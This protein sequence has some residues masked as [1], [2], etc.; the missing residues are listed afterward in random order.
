L[1]G[2]SEGIPHLYVLSESSMSTSARPAL[3]RKRPWYLI[4]AL[5]CAWVFGASAMNEGCSTVGFYKT[6]RSELTSTVQ[7][8]AKDADRDAV[9][10][11]TNGYFSVMD[12][13]KNR[14]FPLGVASLLLGGVMWGFAAGAMAGRA[15]ARSS[16]LQVICVHATVVV[17][18]FM[19]TP[20]VRAAV[21]DADMKLSSLQP[22]PHSAPLRE[23]RRLLREHRALVPVIGMSLHLF[24]YGLVL[25][26]LTR[27]RSREFFDAASA[28]R[29]EQ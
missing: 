27:R 12:G 10:Q 5:V 2:N 17:L 6:D 14:V 7:E 4:L 20:D 22:E 21:V 11:I 3:G 28:A 24:G 29:A 16:L 26:A 15:G 18:A 8:L 23:A 1:D 9:A 25:L 13:A 19:L